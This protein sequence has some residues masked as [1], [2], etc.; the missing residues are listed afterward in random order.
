MQVLKAEEKALL[1]KVKSSKAWE[2]LEA[3][4]EMEARYCHPEDRA[5]M[6]ERHAHLREI[7]RESEFLQSIRKA[8]VSNAAAVDAYRAY[9]VEHPD[10]HSAH[11]Y[12]A[13]TLRL[14]GDLD[15][16]LK[17]F[18]QVI[19]MSGTDSI[20]GSSARLA[21]AEVLRQKGET[22]AALAE[23]RAI[24]KEA[25]PRT[26]VAVG[27]ACLTLGDTL[28]EAGERG[29]ARAAW[30]KAIQWDET[31]LIAKKARERLGMNL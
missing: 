11:S 13:G 30:K 6:D 29:E 16:S 24:V 27:M 9:L 18:G 5:E 1:G 15:G 20:P 10:S 7:R 2:G 19:Q 21:S 8:A 25:T 31:G 22:E 4:Q 17:E 28:S 14:M 23:L 3:V 26:R 12:L